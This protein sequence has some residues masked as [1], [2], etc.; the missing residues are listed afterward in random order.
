MLHSHPIRIPKATQRPS[1]RN[2]ACV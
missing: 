2:A 1:F